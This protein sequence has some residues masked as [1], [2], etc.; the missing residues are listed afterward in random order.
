MEH[1]HINSQYSHEEVYDITEI[2][3]RPNG[4]EWWSARNER[5]EVTGMY[6][7]LY[8]YPMPKLSILRTKKLFQGSSDVPSHGKKI[9]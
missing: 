5:L 2:H 3:L 6:S 4:E 7:H 1:A 8:A 9:L